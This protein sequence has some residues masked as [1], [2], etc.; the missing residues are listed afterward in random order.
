M[1]GWHVFIWKVCRC[2]LIILGRWGRWSRLCST[3]TPQVAR[4]DM[5]ALLTVALL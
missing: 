1:Y 5:A 4:L 2:H 3:C